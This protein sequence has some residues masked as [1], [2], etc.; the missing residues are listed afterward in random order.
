MGGGGP[1]A[2][3]GAHLRQAAPDTSSREEA[4]GRPGSSAPTVFGDEADGRLCWGQMWGIIAKE[5]SR[6]I[7]LFGFMNYS[8]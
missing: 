5:E 4:S 2:V 7:P 6:R 8:F 1:L 3:E